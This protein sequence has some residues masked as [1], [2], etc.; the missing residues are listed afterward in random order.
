MIP[1]TPTALA[2]AAANLY[3]GTLGGGLADLRRMP[4]T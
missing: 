1:L 3:D 2:E 4:S